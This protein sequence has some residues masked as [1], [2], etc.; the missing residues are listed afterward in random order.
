MSKLIEINNVSFAVKNKKI[1]DNLSLTIEET[2]VS[3]IIGPNGAGKTTLLKL[4]AKIV[5]PTSGNI[6]YNNFSQNLPVGFVFQKSILLKRT[7]RENLLHALKSAQIKG[8]NESFNEV[9]DNK[10]K[11]NN[12]YHLSE[13]PAQKLSI[14]QQQIVSIVRA[15]IIN[16]WI[17]FLDEPTSSLDS[18]YTEIVEK[19][20]K[21]E[22]RN[23]KIILVSQNL[24]QTGI[25]NKKAICLNNG[26]LK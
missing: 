16:P 22:S 19:I 13:I 26:K 8:T 7:V 5:N 14:G 10:L 3:L 25:S 21:E 12:I 9:I 23:I 6:I 20:I 4:M 24:N 18:S 1:I 15:L 11:E 17:L 2:G